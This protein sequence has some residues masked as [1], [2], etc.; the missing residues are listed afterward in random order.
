[1]QIRLD[2]IEDEPFAW[3]EAETIDAASLERSDLLGLTKIEWSGSVTKAHP[4]YRFLAELR[5]GQTLA[6][7]RCLKQYEMPVESNVDLIA[8]IRP[9]APMTGEAQLEASDLG[10]LALDTETLDTDPILL[11]QL[12]L[13]VPMRVLCRPECAGLCPSCG[14]DRNETPD[15]CDG[16]EI[17]PR[18]QALKNLELS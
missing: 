2:L 3:S 8:M 9:T 14:A 13:N 1:M 17:D 18:W 15:C 12:D 6:C 5:Y 11:E 10:V 16:E 7:G 4:G